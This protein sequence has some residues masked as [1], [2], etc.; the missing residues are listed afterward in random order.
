MVCAPP[1]PT[2]LTA[3]IA[4]IAF[5]F[6]PRTFQSPLVIHKEGAPEYHRPWCPVVRDG[7]DVVALTRAQAEARGLTSHA[8]CEKDPSEESSAR[9][10]AGR[11]SRGSAPTPIQFVYVDASKYYHREKCERP[12]GPRSRVALDVAGKTRWPCPACRPPVRRMRDA[13]AVPRR[14]GGR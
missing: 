4:T 11:T 7:K 14:G 6:A 5:G 10:T 13:P 8:A 9:G 1:I 12:V 2:A 3:I